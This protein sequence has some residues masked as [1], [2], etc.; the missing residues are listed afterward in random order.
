MPPGVQYGR[1]LANHFV[2]RVSG[3]LG[4]GGIDLHDAILLIGDHQ[5]LAAVLEHQSGQTQFLGIGFL[6]RDVF[7]E[8]Q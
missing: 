6:C 4:E 7:M 3:Q 8:P 1:I 2:A 5:R